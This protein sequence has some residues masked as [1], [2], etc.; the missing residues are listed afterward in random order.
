MRQ[1]VLALAACCFGHPAFAQTPVD[2]PLPDKTGL[3]HG[4]VAS[5]VGFSP[6]GTY[7]WAVAYG[8]PSRVFT[9][10]A[11][12]RKPVL[13]APLDLLRGPVAWSADEKTIAVVAAQANEPRWR[14]ALVD[15]TTGK[16]T[17][18]V[19]PAA[20]HESVYAAQFTPDGRRLVAVIQDKNR[21]FLMAVYDSKSGEQ[22]ALIDLNASR[23]EAPGLA[24]SPDG[25]VAATAVG[26][27][28]LWDI[29]TG[30]LL[31]EGGKRSE[32]A[33]RVRF[34]PN[35]RELVV[36]LWDQKLQLWNCGDPKE[37]TF[38]GA[39]GGFTRGD[40][41]WRGNL[42]AF[43]GGKRFGYVGAFGFEYL[44]R[45]GKQPGHMAS[46]FFKDGGGDFSPDGRLAVSG[47]TAVRVWSAADTL[48]SGA[49]AE[50]LATL[51]YR[52]G[53]ALSGDDSRLVAYGD[54]WAAA[55]DAATGKVLGDVK[56]NASY[57]GADSQ[58]RAY[59]CG[60]RGIS[61]VDPPAGRTT[62]V[63][64]T[65]AI[66]NMLGKR[67]LNTPTLTTGSD[68][69]RHVLL[70]RGGEFSWLLLDEA[71][72]PIGDARG[73]DF[74]T[75]LLN[76]DAKRLLVR[77]NDATMLLFDT[78]T[79]KQV[80]ELKVPP[81]GVMT[82]LALA[83][84]GK[85]LYGTN[86]GWVWQLNLSTL[87]VEYP[88]KGQDPVAGS[89]DNKVFAVARKGHRVAFAG[90]GNRIQVWDAETGKLVSNLPKPE[91]W[92]KQVVLNSTGTVLYAAVETTPRGKPVVF[93]IYKW[94][95]TNGSGG[96][97]GAAVGPGK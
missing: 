22:K 47:G 26:E 85:Y 66:D 16:E 13:S 79:G 21:Q 10:T 55:I 34:L 1:L 44:D 92:V 64:T 4:G 7:V 91:G 38:S 71:L 87:N 43:D 59:A 69:K 30:N 86:D 46:A 23:H 48:K 27:L 49:A 78:D 70:R 20:S 95:L 50:V 76:T 58:G 65:A 72:K 42:H 51:G 31:S 96:G 41:A 3:D 45:D 75:L 80:D 60:G 39:V 19:S 14:F 82:P 54:D 61:V 53:M 77:A 37:L 9:W 18:S 56:A 62:E 12:D 29:A 63:L 32:G 40:P 24:I 15:T 28:R 57:Q 35:G 93:Q 89:Y 68:G 81:G 67:A 73:K 6:K 33:F 2:V 97:A 8:K 90:T 88:L 83:H 5:R 25:T 74:R 11:Q 84:D 36:G 17:G 52:K 94:N